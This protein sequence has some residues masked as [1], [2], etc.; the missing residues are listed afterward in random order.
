MISFPE[1]LVKEQQEIIDPFDFKVLSWHRMGRK[2]SL[3]GDE[4]FLEVIQSRTTRRAFSALEEHVLD[5]FF[6]Q[7]LS[8]RLRFRNEVGQLVGSSR[9]INAGGLNSV[10]CL[11]NLP[12]DASWY[13]YHPHTHSYGKLLEQPLQDI[14]DSARCL[15][16]DSDDASLLWF[17]L[18]A[19]RL[20]AKYL[21][22]LT[23]AWRETGAIMA[24]Q[25]LIA[26]SMRL[27]YCPLGIHGYEDAK[28]LSSERQLLGTGFA[29]VGGQALI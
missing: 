16:P 14:A 19:T 2:P 20:G 9:V 18:D 21:N 4:G 25:S 10:H 3:V 23:L 28:C 24:T 6:F 5:E 27:S 13:A 1:P 26:E 8:T 29:L 17:I 15:V 12:T 7:S 11:F 22:G